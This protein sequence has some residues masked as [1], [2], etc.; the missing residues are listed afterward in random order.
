VDLPGEPVALPG[1]P[2]LLPGEPALLP[3]LIGGAAAQES[4][5]LLSLTKTGGAKRVRVTS[6]FRRLRRSG[7]LIRA[8]LRDR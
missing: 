5:V 6:S 4:A 2:A 8:A 3:A 1:E 7:T